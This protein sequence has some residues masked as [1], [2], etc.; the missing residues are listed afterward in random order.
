M[1][2]IKY[3]DSENSDF[4]L[5]IQKLDIYLA[6]IDGDEYGFFSQYNTVDAIKNVVLVYDED[7]PVGCGSFKYFSEGIA[8]VKRMY[9]SESHRGK[10][11]AA[12]I[13]QTLERWAKEEGFSA[14]ILDTGKK[15][16]PAV[17]F[18]LKNG[19]NVIDNFGPYIG[20]ESSVC[21][22]KTL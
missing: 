17:Q 14:C 13:L 10:G 7:E 21:F 15:M 4:L 12:L 16:K 6:L 5:L 1:L 18:Y 8:E 20:V 9:V 3:T 11:T 2:H 22:S 19:Y